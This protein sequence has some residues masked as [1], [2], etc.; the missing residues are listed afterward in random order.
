M[1]KS[2]ILFLASF[3]FIC[4]IC[5]DSFFEIKI[6]HILLIFFIPFLLCLIFKKGFS[7]IKL[8]FSFLLIFFLFFGIFWHKKALLP[9]ENHEI[10][11][12]FEKE[13]L[14][15]AVI[16]EDVR[17]KENTQNFKVKVLNI[18]GKEI[19]EST[20][21]VISSRY[22]QYEYGQKLKIKGVLEAPEKIEDFDYPGYL[23]KEGVFGVLRFGEIEVV[24]SGFGNPIKSL[25]FLGKNKLKESLSRQ[26]SIPEAGLMEALLFGEEEKIPDSWKEKINLAGFRHLAAV[27]GMNITIIVF[28]VLNFF[29][30]LG[31]WRKEALIF[32]IVFI[33]FFILMIGFSSS[34][35]RAGIMGVLFLLSQYWGR[36]FYSPR[37]LVFT[38]ALMLIDNPLLLRHDL[39]FQ[40]SFLAMLGLIYFQPLF[41]NLFSK[42][43]NTFQLKN[44]L[45]A[46]LSAQIFTLPVLI[47]SFGKI[48]LVSPITNI[49]ITPFLP[50]ITVLGFISAILGLIC[51][52]LAVPFSFSVWF[53][54][55]YILKIADFFSSIPPAGVSF[56]MPPVL[57]A[58]FY[59]VLCVF[60]LKIQEKRKVKLLNY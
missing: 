32:S 20:V 43:P 11:T 54:L 52:V 23:K 53:F 4:G 7:L 26:I 55:S 29:L 47:S 49:L 8:S 50:L 17:A 14:I 33:F 56:R 59:I 40:L 24:G 27:S 30:F 39:G 12:F 45:S 6:Q 22:P 51:H 42:I 9:F 41:L 34:A 16:S 13:I 57:A 5:I 48:S 35:V 10:Q 1:S 58:I 36:M 60:V 46:T 21:L 3:G 19:A 18:D 15:T 25:L 2:K 31:F 38:A 28:L 44:S 37:I